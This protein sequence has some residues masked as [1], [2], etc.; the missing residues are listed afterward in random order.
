[1]IKDLFVRD[2]DSETEEND[3]REEANTENEISTENFTRFV[4]DESVM[5]SVYKDKVGNV[6]VDLSDK[7]DPSKGIMLTA[8]AV[9]RVNEI[10][11]DV[12]NGRKN[13]QVRETLN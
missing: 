5:M 8:E 12:F 9:V 7:S 3:V 1:M 2:E 11:M 13:S 4:A 6:Y 10:M